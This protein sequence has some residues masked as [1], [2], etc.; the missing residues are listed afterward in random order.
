MGRRSDDLAETTTSAVSAPL[1]GR[2]IAIAERCRQRR[3][4]RSGPASSMTDG[5]AGRGWT[6]GHFA[7][8]RDHWASKP[9]REEVSCQMVS[10]NKPVGCGGAFGIAEDLRSNCFVATNLS[11][12]VECGSALSA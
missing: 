10:H 9:V 5:D 2:T 3:S 8:L 11:A 6:H 1:D 12:I 4:R 7:Q